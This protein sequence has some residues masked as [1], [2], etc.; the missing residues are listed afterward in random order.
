[1][2]PNPRVFLIQDGKL[3][4]FHDRDSMRRWKEDVPGNLQRAAQAWTG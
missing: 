3:Y 2:A 1:M 4:L